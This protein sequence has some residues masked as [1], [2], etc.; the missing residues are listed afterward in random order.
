MKTYNVVTKDN[1]YL[2]ANGKFTSNP[3]LA[4]VYESKEIAEQIADKIQGIATT[5]II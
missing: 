3:N 1:K 4:Y 5:L 2:T